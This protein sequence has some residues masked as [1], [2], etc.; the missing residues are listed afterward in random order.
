MGV[1]WQAPF[2]DSWAYINEVNLE[3]PLKMGD[4]VLLTPGLPDH[5]L[6]IIQATMNRGLGRSV[7]SPSLCNEA[8]IGKPV[9]GVHSASMWANQC[10]HT[11]KASDTKLISWERIPNHTVK[12]NHKMILWKWNVA[13]AVCMTTVVPA[14][15]LIQFS[16]VLTPGIFLNTLCYLSKPT[17]TV[18]Q[19]YFFFLL[20]KPRRDCHVFPRNGHHHRKKLW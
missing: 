4:E 7:P 12:Q 19:R 18:E 20:D 11:P 5:W 9:Q 3:I 13:L 6:P 17:Q 2:N 14:S 10:F 8:S 16:R 15:D 1:L